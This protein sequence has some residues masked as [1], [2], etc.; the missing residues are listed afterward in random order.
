MLDS[1]NRYFKIINPTLLYLMLIL[2][3]FHIPCVWS[4]SEHPH[5]QLHWSYVLHV[6][7][8]WS[9]QTARY[10]YY[11]S[12][13]YRHKYCYVL[14]LVVSVFSGHQNSSFYVKSCVSPDGRYL[15]SGSSCGNAFMWQVGENVDFTRV[16]LQ[17]SKIT[18]LLSDKPSFTCILSLL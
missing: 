16:W 9:Q 18:T 2:Y 1:T 14:F 10:V 5:C 12:P 3:R 11:T 15:L 7:L 6:Q 17:F 13:L 4:L 8:D